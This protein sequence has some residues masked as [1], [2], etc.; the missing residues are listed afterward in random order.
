MHDSALDFLVFV[1]ALGISIAIGFNLVVP[2]LKQSN[3]LYYSE[4]YD[5][6]ADKLE[7]DQAMNTDDGCMTR[8]EI[9]LSAMGQT[10]FMPEPGHLTVAGTDIVVA[11]NLA[12]SPNSTNIGSQVLTA[13]N[14]WHSAFIN[15]STAS[16]FTG[17]PTVVTSARFRIEFDMNNADNKTDDS[18]SVYILLK[19][20]TAGAKYELYKCISGGKVQD[21]GGNVL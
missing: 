11:N 6:T 12:F 10:Y 2:I 8:D 1:L 20:N 3:E 14:N 5:K 21:K 15:S 16:K 4:I 7:G 17:I 18:Y 19:R 13:L 9:A